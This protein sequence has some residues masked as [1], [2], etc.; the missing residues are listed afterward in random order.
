MTGRNRRRMIMPAMANGDSPFFF[1]FFSS[2]GG[3]VVP[4]GGGALIPMIVD[5]GGVGAT[6]FFGVSIS[7]SINELREFASLGPPTDG[8]TG[9]VGGSGGGV[10]T[11]P[12]G[13][14]GD[15]TFCS[16]IHK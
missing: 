3:G 7:E 1:T 14:G 5:D 8:I 9:I 11:V 4:S 12:G 13:E 6:A 10:G 15:D 16:D 2:T